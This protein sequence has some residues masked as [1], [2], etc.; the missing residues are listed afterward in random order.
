MRGSVQ[1]QPRI[2]ILPNLKINEKLRLRKAGDPARG[3][4][5][6]LNEE[7]MKETTLTMPERCHPPF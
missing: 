3:E 1:K 7:A 4:V 6:K 2:K 5:E